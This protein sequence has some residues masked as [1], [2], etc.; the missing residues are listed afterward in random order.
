MKASRLLQTHRVFFPLLLSFSSFLFS[1]QF[2]DKALQAYQVTSSTS[3]STALS[4]SSHNAPLLPS[5][6][7]A[8]LSSQQGE[9]SV[10][11]SFPSASSVSSSSLVVSTTTASLPTPGVCTSGGGGGLASSPRVSSST[12]T[13]TTYLRRPIDIVPS[14]KRS[15]SGKS[16]FSSSSSPFFT[17]SSPTVDVSKKASP[18]PSITA[19][20]RNVSSSPA[21]A[22]SSDPSHE[23]KFSRADSSGST[24]NTDYPRESRPLST[25][26]PGG[27]SGRSPL[28]AMEAEEDDGGEEKREAN[29]RSSSLL[30]PLELSYLHYKEEQKARA[31]Q[32]EQAGEGREEKE[33]RK[34]RTSERDSSKVSPSSIS[35]EREV[36]DAEMREEEMSK[37]IKIFSPSLSK[38]TEAPQEIPSKRATK[39]SVS[40]VH[41][42]S[43]LLADDH[44][45]FPYRVSVEKE[46]EGHMVIDTEEREGRSKASGTARGGKESEGESVDGDFQDASSSFSED[47]E[48]TKTGLG[49]ER[50]GSGSMTERLHQTR[51]PR[52]SLKKKSPR[53]SSSSPRLQHHRA[54]LARE[55]EKERREEEEEKEKPF[56]SQGDVFLSPVEEDA[57]KSK[58]DR[59]I[60]KDG[61]IPPPGE[62]RVD[63]RDSS[64]SGGSPM[65]KEKKNESEE[66]RFSPSLSPSSPESSALPGSPSREKLS[67]LR[68]E[69][70]EKVEK[71]LGSNTSADSHLPSRVTVEEE[72]GKPKESGLSS[73]SLA[74][75]ASKT[76]LEYIRHQ[77]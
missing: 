35:R 18:S 31:D 43:H 27:L 37:K 57:L 2:L 51:S 38:P 69:E 30:E 68:K 25:P 60:K 40:G 65:M 71:K 13:S 9:T 48:E 39:E 46:D 61:E 73:S 5:S 28:T 34:E 3:A 56:T 36:E 74:S 10:S 7:C 4:S 70:N 44:I 12:S 24:D 47:A 20:G 41:S 29:R 19:T 53:S 50:I 1:L 75:H 62:G 22:S 52:E 6:S 21:S 49:N 32:D 67:L 26:S 54:Q 33:E 64:S 77:R 59:E 17:S 66:T 45:A 23:M 58:R 16:F 11:S 55:Q 42:A 76:L 15:G 8:P 72:E 14:P 63:T